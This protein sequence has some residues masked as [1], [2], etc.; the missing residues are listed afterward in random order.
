MYYKARYYDPVLGR[1]LQADSI[2]MPESMFGMNR[3]MYVSGSP[4]NVRD[5]SGH[6][7]VSAMAG[8]IAGYFFA[9]QSGSPFSG[10]EGAA[11]GMYLAGGKHSTGS[12][13]KDITGGARWAGTGIGNGARWAGSG[14]DHTVRWMSGGLKGAADQFNKMTNQD[15]A[16]QSRV[17]YSH[18]GVAGPYGYAVRLGAA[19]LTGLC[20]LATGI[21]EFGV[22]GGYDRIRSGYEG[23]GGGVGASGGFAKL[24]SMAFGGDFAAAAASGL[25]IAGVAITGIGVIMK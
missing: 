9:S 21:Y 2:V 25:G 15:Y 19:P 14:I 11:I 20:L 17:N 5:P 18:C 7:G 22:R 6:A 13:A 3:Y 8:A 12:V 10:S 16:K 1:F 24:W 4:T 23:L